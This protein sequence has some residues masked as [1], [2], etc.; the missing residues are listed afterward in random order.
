MMVMMARMGGAQFR[1]LAMM[2]ERL[3]YM[4]RLFEQAACFRKGLM[5]VQGG[6]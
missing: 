2:H 1:F 5:L 6:C 3:Y 4:I